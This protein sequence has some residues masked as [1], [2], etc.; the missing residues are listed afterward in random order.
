VK[1]IILSASKKKD[2]FPFCETRTKS[3]SFCSGVTILER[4]IT[5]LKLLGIQDICLVVNHQKQKIQNYF[6]YGQSLGVNL[7][8]I[9][10]KQDGIGNALLQ[11][12][13]FISEEHF[14]LVYGDILT[15][16]Q[17]FLSFKHF[18]ETSP[19][20]SVASLVHP[21]C[22]GNFGHA[23]INNKLQI[24]KIVEQRNLAKMTS[25]YVLSGIYFLKK[26]IFELLKKDSSMER[27]YQTLIKQ[28][29]IYANLSEEDWVDITFP[30]NMMDASRIIMNSWKHSIIP[31]SVKIRRGVYIK[32]IVRMGE[33]CEILSGTSIQG[34]C[35][36]GDNVFIGNNCLIREY[37]SLEKNSIIGFGTEIKSSILFPNVVLGRLSFIGDSVIGENA[38]VGNFCTTINYNFEK[39]ISVGKKNTER[40]KM[41]VFIGDN[42]LVGS[43]HSL[44]AGLVIAND[45]I[46]KN[47]TS[48]TQNNIDTK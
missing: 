45:K 21:A 36:I 39:T 35:Y 17:H 6:G 37:S 10:Q 9:D 20:Y 40:K 44:E 12:E 38:E 8:Y 2:F 30:W 14:F 23:Y 22:A 48:L 26:D 3:M 15:T 31:D 25:N 28:Q 29:K 32:G 1:A 33:N 34:P 16:N 7:T 43:N 18:I 24:T 27:L 41:G 19:N 11:A 47:N 46:I 4:I 13:N 42:A 5:Q